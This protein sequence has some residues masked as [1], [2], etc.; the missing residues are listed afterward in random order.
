MA[1]GQLRRR[2]VRS[3]DSQRHL[4]IVYQVLLDLLLRAVAQADADAWKLLVKAANGVNQDVQDQVLRGGDMNL[5]R[6]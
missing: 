2:L 3:R 4:R 1:I 6:G 5:L